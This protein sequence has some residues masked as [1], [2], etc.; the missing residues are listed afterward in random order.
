MTCQTLYCFQITY[1][2][3]TLQHTDNTLQHTG[4]QSIYFLCNLVVM[5]AY[6]YL[7]CAIAAEVIATLLLPKT[8]EFKKLLPS[9]LCI[10]GYMLAFYFMT[11]SMRSISVGVTYAIW[12]GVGIVLITLSA[13]FIYE[14]KQDWAAIIG[15]TFIII[16]VVIINLFSQTTM[17]S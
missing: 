2:L 17:K 3:S 12:S 10:L 16:G 14:Q 4:K 15:M 7:G 8:Q 13:Y 9:T 11:L 6:I 5:K 1:H